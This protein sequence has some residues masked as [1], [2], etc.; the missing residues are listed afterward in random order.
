MEK[1][2]RFEYL[3][4]ARIPIQFSVKLKMKLKDISSL[5]SNNTNNTTLNLWIKN[6]PEVLFENLK[7]M[8]F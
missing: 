2:Q 7:Y 6:F 5:K 8:C 3:K 1:V 4:D